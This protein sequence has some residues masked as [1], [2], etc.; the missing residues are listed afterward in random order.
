MVTSI[1]AIP[2][3]QGRCCRFGSLGGG[4]GSRVKWLWFCLG[5]VWKVPKLGVWT[6]ALLV[7]G[8]WDN[9]M[10]PRSNQVC[11][12]KVR[13][14]SSHCWRTAPCRNVITPSWLSK[15]RLVKSMIRRFLARCR[16]VTGTK[17]SKTWWFWCIFW[18]LQFLPQ[19]DAT[20]YRF[21]HNNVATKWRLDTDFL[22]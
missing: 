9:F 11:P 5:K 14:T 2:N 22:T 7:S 3:I 20:I 1:A 12:G 15:S 18:V 6:Q 4:A 8:H 16:C 21:I 13:L 10:K 17:R 19:V